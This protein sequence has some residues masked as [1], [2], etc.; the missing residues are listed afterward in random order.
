MNLENFAPI[1]VIE[2]INEFD[3]DPNCINQ[4][5]SDKIFECEKENKLREMIRTNYSI[6]DIIQFLIIYFKE[7]PTSVETQRD[8]F[9]RLFKLMDDFKF[10][11]GIRKVSVKVDTDINAN[12]TGLSV[13][14]SVYDS[15]NDRNPWSTA[16]LYYDEHFK[17]DNNQ[18]ALINALMTFIFRKRR[19]M[20]IVPV[21]KNSYSEKEDFTEVYL[22]EALK[23]M[24]EQPSFFIEISIRTIHIQTKNK[25]LRWNYGTKRLH[26]N[27]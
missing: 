1:S 27:K 13:L 18:Q 19:L 10:S 14:T 4:F 6:H 3:A 2:F 7:I 12:F 23:E 9:M 20:W 17:I 22:V 24:I 11:E 15:E 16:P 25:E 26:Y 8:I 5:L 21:D